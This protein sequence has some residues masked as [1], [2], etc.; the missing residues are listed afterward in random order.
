MIQLK[1]LT[2]TTGKELKCGGGDL[3]KINKRCQ[4]LQIEDRGDL[5]FFFSC[6]Y[7]SPGSM[8]GK[9]RLCPTAGRVNPEWQEDTRGYPVWQQGKSPHAGER[10]H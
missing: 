6:P 7:V 9:V 1:V 8:M 2:I 3:L 4:T 5:V 10:L